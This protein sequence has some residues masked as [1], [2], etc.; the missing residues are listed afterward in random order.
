[1][2][3]KV[4]LPSGGKKFQSIQIRIKL[5]GLLFALCRASDR[6]RSQPEQA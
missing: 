2:F 4:P 1:M 5:I 3:R 6:G